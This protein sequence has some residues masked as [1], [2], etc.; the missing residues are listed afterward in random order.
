MAGR[1]SAQKLRIVSWT[2]SEKVTA[3]MPTDVKR[4]KMRRRT[5]FTDERM[6][7]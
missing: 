5:D 2:V 6:A 4:T 1:R 3:E 7:I